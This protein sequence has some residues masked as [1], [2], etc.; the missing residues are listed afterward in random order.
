MKT[1]DMYENTAYLQ[2]ETQT[3]A[4]NRSWEYYWASQV[5]ENQICIVNIQWTNTQNLEKN[6]FQGPKDTTDF[7]MRKHWSVSQKADKKVKGQ[8]SR[9]RGIGTEG[10]THV[11]RG[12]WQK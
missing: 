1:S 3:L 5:N 6:A 12:E 4:T 10:V 8:P 9:K 11:S 7:G 2:P